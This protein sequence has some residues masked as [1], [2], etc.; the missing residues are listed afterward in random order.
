MAN[1]CRMDNVIPGFSWSRYALVMCMFI[2]M[3][4]LAFNFITFARIIPE[5]FIRDYIVLTYA[6]PNPVSMFLSNYAH[7][8]IQHL[9]ENMM[10]YL[11]TVAFIF[12]VALVAIP[13]FNKHTPGVNCRF[14]TKT[15]VQSTAVFFLIVPFIISTESILV[16]N[17]LGIAGGFGFSGVVFAFEGYMVYISEI[18]IIRKIQ[19]VMHRRDKLLAYSGMFLAVMIPLIVVFGQIMTMYTTTAFNANYAAHLTGFV[20]GV[21]TPFLIERVERARDGFKYRKLLTE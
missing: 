7:A 14:G 21:V 3:A 13:S 2:P 10:S 5:D 4:I 16:G 12:A 11:I 17:Y 15:L 18:L 1:I 6:S 9:S 19:V 8:N 20:V